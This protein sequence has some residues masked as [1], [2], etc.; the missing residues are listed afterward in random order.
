MSKVIYIV[1]DNENKNYK[2][3]IKEDTII[4]HFSINS[5]SEVI[6]DL[7]KEGVRLDYYYNNINYDDNK[8]SIK[9]NHLKKNTHSELYNHGVNVF[10]NKLMYYVDGVVLKNSSKC[11]CNQDNQIINMD[12]GKSAICPNL[13]IDN[14]DV[15]SNHAAYIGKFK[16]EAMFYLMSR[17]ISREVAYRLL[18]NGF[19]INSDSIE[20]DKIKLFL[21]EIEKI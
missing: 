7:D 4:Y 9:V 10:C 20:K 15:D 18:L 19:L 17:G 11:I 1:E 6:I 21:D 8:F 3:N 13:L 16:D 5:S 14:Y 12:N 2:Y